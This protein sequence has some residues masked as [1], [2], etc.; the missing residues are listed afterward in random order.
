MFIAI[1]VHSWRAPGALRNRSPAFAT[2]AQLLRRHGD[3]H[4]DLSA[5]SG[6]NAVSRDE[7]SG[8][9]FL[10]GFQDTAG[11]RS[12]HGRCIPGRGRSGAPGDGRRQ[13]R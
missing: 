9:A 1:H 5:R 3:L 8:A 12:A 10:E 7:D 4:G 2:L 11:R 6:F 13:D